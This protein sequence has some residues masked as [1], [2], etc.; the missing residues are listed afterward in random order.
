[1]DWDNREELVDRP[2]VRDRTEDGKITQILRRQ[3]LPKVVEL[4]RFDLCLLREIIRL[5]ADLPEKHFAFRAVFQGNEAEV[6][7]REELFFM[8]ERVVVILEEILR[9]H[10]LIQI[11]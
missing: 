11:M 5:V 2:V 1:M 3:K 10:R 6:E 4:L 9:G 7:E 8:L